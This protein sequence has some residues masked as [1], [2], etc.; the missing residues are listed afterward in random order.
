MTKLWHSVR[1]F[2][3]R[4]A[5]GK[6]DFFLNSDVV[7]LSAGENASL[8]YFVRPHLNSIGVRFDR[9]DYGIGPGAGFSWGGIKKIVLVRYLPPDWIAPLREYCNRGGKII[10]FMDD[11]LFDPQ[12]LGKLPI[13]YQ[14]KIKREV[15]NQ[16]QFIMNNCDEFWVSSNYLAEK[17]AYKRP[18]ILPPRPVSSALECNG[19]I[20]FA[21]HG[22]S[23]HQ[24]ELKWL[25]NI[26]RRVQSSNGATRFEVFGDIAVNRLYRD[27]PRT[28]IIHPMS[29][30]LYLSYTSC[31]RRD[32]GLAPL[33]GNPFNAARSPTKFFDFARMQSVGIYSD[34]APYRD[35]IRP[36]VDGLLLP[37]C[38]D[39]WVEEITKLA[40]N[41]RLREKM[42][43]SACERVRKMIAE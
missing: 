2:F 7:V 11:D 20:T 28:A 40:A 13:A 16:S 37:N 35:F 42:A 17:Y 24:E 26:V 4:K 8:A 14:K 33:L 27:I 10:Y 30:D 32:I 3:S 23:S 19:S 41:S 9:L 29:W 12:A 22:S 34:V 39:V 38:P 21:Y 36:G 1:T 15:I 43:A 6:N 31:T 5:V 18:K 25:V